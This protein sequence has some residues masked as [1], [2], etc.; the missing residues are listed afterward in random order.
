MKHKYYDVI[1]AWAEDKP[2]EFRIVYGDN[3]KSDWICFDD[4]GDT[5]KSPNFDSG[6]IEWRVKP[7]TKTIKYRLALMSYKSERYYTAVFTMSEEHLIEFENST[8]FVK[9]ISDWIE[10]EVEE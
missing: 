8:N 4:V 2:I 7:Q 3:T 1:M 9:W 10:Q 6:T 5:K